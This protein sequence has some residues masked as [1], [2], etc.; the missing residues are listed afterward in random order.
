MRY[1][2]FPRTLKAAQVSERTQ[3]D[4]GDALLAE[5]DAKHTGTRGLNAVV[6]ELEDNGIELGAR[7]LGNLRETAELFPPK[8]RHDLPWKVHQA[9]GNPDVLDTIVRAA[10]KD[11][12][13]PKVTMRY[14]YGVLRAQHKAER[15]SRIEAKAIA[16]AA[17]EK[18]QEEERQ[19]RARERAAKKANDERELA[20][21]NAE[22][23]RAK[24]R[25]EEAS[26]IARKSRVVSRKKDLQAPPEADIPMMVIITSL[27]A[28]ANEAERLARKSEKILGENAE[29]LSAVQIAGLT[30]AAISAAN[31]WNRFA[32]AIRAATRDKRGHLSVVN[33]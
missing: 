27:L 12:N 26:D 8:R 2:L 31:A 6:Q 4:V 20:R 7:Y 16:D 1:P 9:A 22:H 30:D 11:P 29:E 10:K 25:T 18:A 19:A 5:A 15:Q 21:A 32:A 33:E 28:H 3:W 13:K 24:K 14:I 17:L 23:E